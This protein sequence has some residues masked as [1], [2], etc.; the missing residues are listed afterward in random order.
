MGWGEV[1]EESRKVLQRPA[2]ALLL[3]GSCFAYSASV[4]FLVC[5]RL[6]WHRIC[7]VARA[8]WITLLVGVKDVAWTWAHLTTIYP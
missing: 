6:N 5:G 4:P 3:T 7:S 1:E 8:G 2:V